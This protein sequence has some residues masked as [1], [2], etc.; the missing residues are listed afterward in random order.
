V[1]IISDTSPINNLAAIGQ[2][3]LLKQLYG[4]IVIPRAV[5][6]E[7]TDPEFP[8]AGATEVQA[9]SWIETCDVE[10]LALVEALTGELDIGEAEA[11]ALAVELKAERLLI[12]ER[13]GRLVADRFSLRYTGILGLLVE[14]K[15]QKLIEKVQPL[16][17]A[18]R[19]QAG[20]WVTEELYQR[21]LQAVGEA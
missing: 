18:L 8:V 10:N 11:I 16:L 21:V 14:A 12:D 4:K 1:L 15:S 9:F 19:N 17:D 6:L 20:F 3:M 5:F 13:R 7:L 2:L